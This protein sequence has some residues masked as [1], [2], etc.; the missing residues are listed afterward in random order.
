MSKRSLLLGL[1]VLTILGLWLFFRYTSLGPTVLWSVSQNGQWLLPVVVIAS[2]IDSINPC[3]FS[4]LL[5]TIAFL[6]SLGKLR[7]RILGIGGAY[8]LGIF[9]VYMLIG[10]GIFQALHLF[11]TPHFMAKIGAVLLLVLGSIHL[12]NE[13]WPSFPIKI[14]LPAALHT[15]M[16][17]LMNNASLPAAF[18]LGS[19]VGLCEFPCTGGPYLTVLGLL[20]DQ[21]TYLAGFGYLLLYNAIFILPL[22][23]MLL[24]ASEPGLLAKVQAWQ[25]RE[26]AHMRLWSGL[27]MI[28]LGLLILIF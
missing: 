18:A 19:L 12:L 26:T 5:L 17:M 21:R 24:V 10:L 11:N 1:G 6:V 4:I 25:K 20:H 27:A 16:A 3:A 23:L 2:L 13:F 9:V 7:S 28:V 8:I 15:R 22:A 14:R